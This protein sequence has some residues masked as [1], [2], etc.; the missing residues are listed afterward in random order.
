[1]RRRSR[2]DAVEQASED[3]RIGFDFVVANWIQWGDERREGLNHVVVGFGSEWRLLAVEREQGLERCE[4]ESSD[5][6][7]GEDRTV[8]NNLQSALDS[9]NDEGEGPTLSLVIIPTPFLKSQAI[10][11]R[12][13][14]WERWPLA[15]RVPSGVQLPWSEVG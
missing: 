14:N 11:P 4:C 12:S 2:I 13:L 8:R 9:T 7:P 10:I 1:M 3:L 15:S 5:L 6:W